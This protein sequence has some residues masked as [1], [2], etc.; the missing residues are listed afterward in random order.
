MT[1]LALIPK[2][3]AVRILR[4][5]ATDTLF[6]CLL[7]ASAGVTRLTA[8]LLMALLEFE[9]GLIMIKFHLKPRERRVTLLTLLAKPLLMGV[10]LVV[11][12]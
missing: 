6:G 7:V 10:L 3:Q 4:L 11:A 2:E 9:F 1:S 12:G 5:V 8:C